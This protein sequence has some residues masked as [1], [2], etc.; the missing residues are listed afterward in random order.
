MGGVGDWGVGYNGVG[1]V[2]DWSGE[3][4]WEWAFLKFHSHTTTPYPPLP[5]HDFHTVSRAPL[6]TLTPHSVGRRST[7]AHSAWRQRNCAHSVSH[8]YPHQS[9]ERG[10]YGVVPLQTRSPFNI[11]VSRGGEDPPHSLT[12]GGE[13]VSRGLGRTG[14]GKVAASKATQAWPCLGTASSMGRENALP[15]RS[16]PQARDPLAKQWRG[17]QHPLDRDPWNALIVLGAKNRA[18]ERAAISPLPPRS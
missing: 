4:V 11:L 1:R 6:P 9:Q 2:C 13:S 10:G 7:I 17:F 3:V 16:A 18:S 15:A 12:P 8:Y 5:L 14:S